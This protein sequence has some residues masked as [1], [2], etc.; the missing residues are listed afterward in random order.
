MIN[1]LL[2]AFDIGDSRISAVVAKVDD[3]KNM[4]IVAVASVEN[5]GIKKSVVVSLEGVIEA[6]NQCRIKL[7]NLVASPIDE[8]YLTIQG[9]LCE[10]VDS[11]GSIQLF[12]EGRKVTAQDVE[13]VKSSSKLISL[14]ADKEIVWISPVRYILD[15]YEDKREPVGVKGRFVTLESKLFTASS[16]LIN[17]MKECMEAA[18]IKVLG[19]VPQPVSLMKFIG[20]DSQGINSTGIINIGA[21]TIDLSIYENGCICYTKHI[22]LGGNSITRD[23]SACLNVSFAD[24]EKIK[25][26]YRKNLYKNESSEKDSEKEIQ[27]SRYNSSMIE[28]VINSRVDELLTFALEEINNCRNLL[29]LDSIYITGNGIL[30]YEDNIDYFSRELGKPIISVKDNLGGSEDSIYCV[31]AGT[32]KAVLESLTVDSKKMQEL[33]SSVESTNGNKR[34]IISKLKHYIEDFL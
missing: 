2:V 31:P 28:E 16:S 33:N 8:A 22:P 15:N 17:R 25:L 18:G 23:L 14:S 12:P 13:E 10:V 4:Q 34:S 24:A 7:E 19:F 11:R 3:L 27:F 26:Q 1:E 5:Y 30:H 32:V 6:V 9:G 21:E 29:A 20:E